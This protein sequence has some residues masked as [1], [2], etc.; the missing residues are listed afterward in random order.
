[1]K[2]YTRRG[3]D[4]TTH[5]GSGPR[6]LKDD[7]CVEACGAVDELNA[8]L[9]VVRAQSLPTDIDAL[10]SRVQHELFGVGADL[11]R[12]AAAG[13][14]PARTST[15]QVAQL[16]QEIDQYDE[17]VSPLQEFILPGGVSS[18]ALLHLARTVCRRAERRAVH[19]RVATHAQREVD[20]IVQYLNRLGDLLFVLPRVLNARTGV[21]DVIWHKTAS[22]NK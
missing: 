20:T 14:E 4:G 19:L 11:A 12:P 21:P 10:L 17:Q 9:G 18:A 22:S 5:L 13:G 15:A 6:V 8:W 3:D 2:L 7:P 16:E 1:M